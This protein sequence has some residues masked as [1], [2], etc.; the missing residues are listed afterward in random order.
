M[1]TQ[2]SV[3][4][5]SV[6]KLRQAIAVKEQIETLQRQLVTL[7]GGVP[8]APARG[9]GPQKMSPAA[10]ARISAAMRARWARVKAG[11]ARKGAGPRKM[12]NAARARISAAMKARWAKVKAAKGTSLRAGTSR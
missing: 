2:N 9:P 3:L 11:K 4:D 10:R 12:S 5:L 1:D 8:S 7:V 6:E